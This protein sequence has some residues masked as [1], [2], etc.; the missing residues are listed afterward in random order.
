MLIH[1]GTYL[2]YTAGQQMNQ[3]KSTGWFYVLQPIASRGGASLHIVVRLLPKIHATSKH[4]HNITTTHPPLWGSEWRVR[5]SLC[6]MHRIAGPFT[7]IER[8]ERTGFSGSRKGLMVHKY[9]W[10]AN[11]TQCLATANSTVF[12]EGIVRNAQPILAPRKALARCAASSKA[13]SWLAP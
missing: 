10:C 9:S 4:S 2:K 7:R 3:T 12:H 8:D 13:L 1:H 11:R 6:R 5:K